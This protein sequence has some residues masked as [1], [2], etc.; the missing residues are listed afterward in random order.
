MQYCGPG[1]LDESIKG[2][3]DLSLISSVLFPQ[4]LPEGRVVSLLVMSLLL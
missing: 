3:I 2:H 4:P 1:C